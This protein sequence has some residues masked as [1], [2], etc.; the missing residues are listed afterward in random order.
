MGR[1]HAI[2]QADVESCYEIAADFGQ[3][4]NWARNNGMQEVKVLEEYPDGR[5]KR[6]KFRAKPPLGP[7]LDNELV[8]PQQ[9][10]TCLCVLAAPL[11]VPRHG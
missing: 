8:I 3:Y 2:E 4:L 9:L 6:V 11:G 7:D 10:F 1:L 5:G